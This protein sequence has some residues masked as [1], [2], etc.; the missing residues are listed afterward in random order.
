M[1]RLWAARPNRRHLQQ[2]WTFFQFLTLVRP[3]MRVVSHA[4]E[5][6]YS[7]SMLSS[8]ACCRLSAVRAAHKVP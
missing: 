8:H 2:L 6:S 5:S 7:T 4:T 1:S 3:C